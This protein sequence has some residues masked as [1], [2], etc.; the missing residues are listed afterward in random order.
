MLEH[1]YFDNAATT[2][3]KPECVHGFAD[4]FYRSH[5]VNPGRSGSLLA[6]EAAEMIELTRRQLAACVGYHGNPARVVFTFNGTDALNM[7]INGSVNDGDHIVATRLEHNAVRRVLHHLERDRGISVTYVSASDD[8]RVAPD[9]IEAALRPDT[10]LIVFTH[11]SN[12]TGLVQPLAEIA[13]V[14]RARGVRLVVDAAQT[15]GV[16]KIDLAQLEG[17]SALAMPSHK[18]L[19]GPMGAGVLVVAEHVELV[20]L[21]VGGTGTESVSRFQPEDYPHRLEAGTLPLPAIAGLHAAQAWLA[22]LGGR[23]EG[24]EGVVTEGA[25]TGSGQLGRPVVDQAW[26]VADTAEWRL[27]E[28]SL[29]LSL[30]D[31]DAAVHA[32]R[33]RRAIEAIHTRELALLAR[34]EARLRQSPAVR[35]IG[36]DTNDRLVDGAVENGR[37][38]TL[39]FV[40]DGML[41]SMLADMLDADHHVIARAGLHCAPMVHED[42]GID[43]EEGAIRLSPGAFTSEAEIEQLLDAFDAILP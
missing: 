27:I 39:S 18:G 26:Q 34:I 13:Q 35:L 40:V 22:E 1:A 17:V 33:T 16:S 36:V 23:I 25:V 11:A 21:R 29:P 6:A 24:A 19:L 31:F 12:V 2:W 20:P 14:A 30:P 32:R 42:A 9:H 38:A 7:A 10:T 43:L 4:R 3:P 8:G 15:A 37:V 41:T 5:G 28:P